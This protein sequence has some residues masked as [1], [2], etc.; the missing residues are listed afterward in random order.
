MG[1]P[2]VRVVWTPVVAIRNSIAVTVAVDTIGDPVAIAIAATHA[3]VPIGNRNDDASGQENSK[4][5]AKHDDLLH[6]A[7]RT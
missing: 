2:V 7:S 3:T 1:L 5:T 4:G 6:G